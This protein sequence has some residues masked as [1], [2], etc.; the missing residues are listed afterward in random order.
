MKVVLNATGFNAALLPLVEKLPSPLFRVVDRPI[1][2]HVIEFFV[3]QG[4]SEFEILLSH[5]PEQI[6]EVLGEGDRWGVKIIYHLVRDFSKPFS[7][8]KVISCSW[9]DS[10]VVLGYASTL[11]KFPPGWIEDRAKFFYSQKGWTGWAILSPRDLSKIEPNCPYFDLPQSVKNHLSISTKEPLLEISC[12]DSWH[13]TNK[14]VVQRGLK[15][16]FPSS[17]KRVK[18]D[19]WLSKSTI[20]PKATLIAPLF[21]G[22][23]CQI[24]QGAKVGPNV[25][26]ESHCVID[27][28]STVIN[29]LI[30]QQSYVGKFL[31]IKDSIIDRTTLIHLS[32]QTI[33]TLHDDF[34]LAALTPPDIYQKLFYSAEK[35]AALLLLLSLSPLF[36]LLAFWQGVKSTQVIQLPLN[37]PSNFFEMFYFP[38]SGILR[39]LPTLI[40]IV[41]GDIHFVGISPKQSDYILCSEQRELYRKTKS[42]LLTLADVDHFSTHPNKLEILA[43]ET[44][45]VAHQK[46]LLD[47]QILFRWLYLHLMTLT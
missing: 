17:S 31:E 38:I 32:L 11:P 29:A 45:Y 47:L 43:S 6:E 3:Q 24:L 23:H 21:I 20:H 7:I 33:L 13:K 41:K 40:N 25:V 2:V 37:D 30:C 36:A 22:D 5:L 27:S 16:I 35:I 8:V 12:F 18:P 44:Y 15:E 4:F 14:R 10:Y 34:I 28:D 42:G 46:A 26:I 1:I 9:K 39:Y 19:I